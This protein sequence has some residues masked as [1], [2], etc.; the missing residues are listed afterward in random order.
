MT[1]VRKVFAEA[2][3]AHAPRI[4]AMEKHEDA[5]SPFALWLEHRGLMKIIARNFDGT[6]RSMEYDCT[7][8]DWTTLEET[9]LTETSQRF[10]AKRYLAGYKPLH[11]YFFALVINLAKFSPILIFIYWWASRS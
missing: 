8:W 11:V 6:P 5:V 1:A 3:K 9:Y 10:K 2:V 4:A 7:S